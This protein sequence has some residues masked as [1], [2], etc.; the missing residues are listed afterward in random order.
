V[1]IKIV[2]AILEES[3]EEVQKKVDKL[4]GISEV[5]GIDIIDG[6]YADNLTVQA[7]DLR[8]VDFG[9]LRVEVQLMT[10]YPS[11]LLGALHTADVVRV[12]GQV[13]RMGR[14]EVFVEIAEDME[15]EVGLALDLFTPVEAI[16]RQLWGR[17]DGI[18]LMSV[19]AGFSGQEFDERVLGKI[20][21]LRREG[22]AGAIQIDGGMK[23]ETIRRCVKAGADEFSVTSYLWQAKNLEEAI[24]KLEDLG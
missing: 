1:R 8:D 10:E 12:F 23:P 15:M 9:E 16:E 13:E 7:E 19:K 6:V 21:E 3:I 14:Q 4:K 20:E 11:D 24:A 18:L 5:V 17:L 2:P 22:F